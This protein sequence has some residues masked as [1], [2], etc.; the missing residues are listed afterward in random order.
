M[1]VLPD[2]H[3][4]TLLRIWFQ[5]GNQMRIHEDSDPTEAKK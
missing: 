2:L 3:D 5:T 4:S 1:L